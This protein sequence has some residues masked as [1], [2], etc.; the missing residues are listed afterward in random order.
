MG[1]VAGNPFERHSG[2]LALYDQGK[3]AASEFPHS[4]RF[5]VE[6]AVVEIHNKSDRRPSWRASSLDTIGKS[7]LLQD[8]FE[9]VKHSCSAS[10]ES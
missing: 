7:V 10:L 9:G 1:D 8:G 4:F 5:G 3:D 2:A 6:S